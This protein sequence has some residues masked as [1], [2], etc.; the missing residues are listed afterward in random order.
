[1]VAELFCLLP[2]I[3]EGLQHQLEP[4]LI[5]NFH[6][7]IIPVLSLSVSNFWNIPVSSQIKFLPPKLFCCPPSNFG[8]LVLYSRELR[9]LT[10]SPFNRIHF[11]YEGF[12]IFLEILKSN[13]ME[14]Q[15]VLRYIY[16]IEAI[17]LPKRLA[18]SPVHHLES[19]N[20]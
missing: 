13:P 10:I 16:G 19:E 3:V 5:D 7:Y 2:T 9:R 14:I 11:N 4:S 1:M 12:Q 8:Y 18:L 20:L 6:E 15:I 17:L